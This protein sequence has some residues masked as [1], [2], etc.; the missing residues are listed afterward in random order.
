M[1]KQSMDARL[2][3]F[4]PNFDKDMMDA[5]VAYCIVLYCNIRYLTVTSEMNVLRPVVL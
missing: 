2:V 4:I 5:T 1:G 3:D